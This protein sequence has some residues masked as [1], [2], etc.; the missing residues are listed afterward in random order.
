MRRIDATAIP[1][2]GTYPT[3]EPIIEHLTRHM[4]TVHPDL[5]QQAWI[6]CGWPSINRLIPHCLGG[7]QLARSRPQANSLEAQRPHCDGW[8]ASTAAFTD[9]V[10]NTAM[11]EAIVI[12]TMLPPLT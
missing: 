11:P 9:A 8:T 12:P 5:W 7:K 2:R 10:G 3:V 4:T 6:R 1:T